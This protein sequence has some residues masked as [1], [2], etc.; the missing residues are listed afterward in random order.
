MH[1]WPTLDWS[2]TCYIST[3]LLYSQTSLLTAVADGRMEMARKSITSDCFETGIS[4]LSERSENLQSFSFFCNE[5]VQRCFLA[6]WIVP[7]ACWPYSIQYG[8]ATLVCKCWLRVGSRNAGVDCV[9]A[10]D[11]W[12]C[13][14]ILVTQGWICTRLI[15]IRVGRYCSPPMKL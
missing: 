7:V 13:L 1:H 8:L 9:P 11:I 6:L 14:I 5:N 4:D 10:V 15:R 12:R 3:F 2:L